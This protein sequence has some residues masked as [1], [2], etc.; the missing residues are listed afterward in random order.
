V[1]VVVLLLFVAIGGQALML[2][3]LLRQNGRLLLRIEAPE[4]RFA[5]A[6]LAAPAPTPPLVLALPIG[7]QTPAFEAVRMSGGKS[8]LMNYAKTIPVVLVFSDPDCGP[9]NAL[10]PDL[11]K[12]R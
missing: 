10:L 7:S 3:Q 12:S 8:V 11:A 5:G 4:A 6:N 1:A 2:V 9:C